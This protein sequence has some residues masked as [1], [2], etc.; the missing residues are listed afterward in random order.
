MAALVVVHRPR[1]TNIALRA[2]GIMMIVSAVV[3]SNERHTSSQTKSPQDS[4]GEYFVFLLFLLLLER[5]ITRQTT[6]SQSKVW[7][8]HLLHS[9]VAWLRRIPIY[10]FILE[11]VNVRSLSLSPS[12]LSRRKLHN[13]NSCSLCL[14][15]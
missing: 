7:P 6:D 3:Y 12:A 10:Q 13:P 11:I 1:N 14:L 2:R 15:F 4:W 9:H 5:A 8:C